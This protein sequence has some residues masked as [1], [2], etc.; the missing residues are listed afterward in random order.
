MPI[1]DRIPLNENASRVRYPVLRFAAPFDLGQYDFGQAANQ[2]VRLM[3]LQPN[4][5]YLIAGISFFANV[6]ESDWLE[7]MDTQA[8]FPNFRLHKEFESS[9][10]IYPEP[11]QCVNYM[12]GVEQLV[13]FRTL[14]DSDNLLISFN[15][16]INQVEG[17]VGADPV[18]AEVNFTMYQ[19]TNQE[20]IRDYLNPHERG[21]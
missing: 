12:D 9:D 4:T 2:N 6:K 1:I 19:V 7:S 20:F 13:Y 18:L 14:R 5:L 10:S 8:N 11:V 17:M 21:H 15:G 3:A 16:V